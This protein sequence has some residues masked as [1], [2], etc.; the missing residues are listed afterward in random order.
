MKHLP[1]HLRPRWRY[2]AVGLESVPDADVHRTTFRRE[3][4]AAARAL[5]GDAGTAELGLAVLEF[6]LEEGEGHAVVRSR[7]DAVGT[8][9][10]AVAC[11][12]DIDGVPIGIHVRG[13]SGTVRG[14]EEKFL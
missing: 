1:K 11:V 14:C 10:A 3:L 5:V 9:R 8:V 4:R 12:H 7:R 13:V 2:L 6:A